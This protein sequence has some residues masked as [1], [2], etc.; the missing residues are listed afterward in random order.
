MSASTAGAD[1]RKRD[2][3]FGDGPLPNFGSREERVCFDLK[4]GLTTDYP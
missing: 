3:H 4:A 1:I 2:S